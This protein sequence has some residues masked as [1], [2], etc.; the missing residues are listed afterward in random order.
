M[1]RGGDTAEG[2]VAVVGGG[3]SGELAAEG[4]SRCRRR[5]EGEEERTNL[6]VEMCVLSP[7]G[8]AR[9]V[10]PFRRRPQA[11]PSELGSAWD[12]G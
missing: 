11:E 8:V 9:A 4:R 3:F 1:G 10:F 2:V 6:L 5:G 7:T 12:A